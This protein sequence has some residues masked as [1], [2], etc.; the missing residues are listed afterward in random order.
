MSMGGGYSPP[1][2]PWL[3]YWERLSGVAKDSD[4]RSGILWCH[5]CRRQRKQSVGAL[6]KSGVHKNL[7]TKTDLQ[8]LYGYNYAQ[9]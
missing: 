9:S 3:R 8:I 5:Q 6:A 2:P 4:T 7:H 1:A